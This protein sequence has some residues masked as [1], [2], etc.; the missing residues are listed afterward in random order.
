MID[1]I[2]SFIKMRNFLKHGILTVIKISFDFGKQKF[3]LIFDQPRNGKLGY[4][5]RTFGNW[6]YS[7]RLLRSLLVFPTM[8]TNDV[9]FLKY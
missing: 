1:C 8:Y 6:S 5:V 4:S 9:M 3:D 7:F 2:L